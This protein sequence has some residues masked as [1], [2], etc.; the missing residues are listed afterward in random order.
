MLLARTG[1]LMGI[2]AFTAP[3]LTNVASSTQQPA[4]VRNSL[5]PKTRGKIA[6]WSILVAIA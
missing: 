1:K 5:P 6:R 4:A 3:R 2:Q